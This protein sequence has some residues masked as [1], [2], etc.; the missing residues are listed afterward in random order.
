MSANISEAQ[1]V[2]NERCRLYQQKCE[3]ILSIPE[4]RFVGL[5][6][7]MGNQIAGGFREDVQP[8]KSAEQ[9]KKM[10]IEAVLR[11]R[12]R[13][14][15]DD[16]LGPVKYAAARRDKVVMMTFPMGRYVLLISAEQNVDIDKTAT[17]IMT[18]WG[19]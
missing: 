16:N 3:R 7:E 11:V 18:V 6:D 12:I 14:E 4:I 15:F 9:R 5:L 19:I 13:E 10:N 17:K 2:K 8:L 1:Y